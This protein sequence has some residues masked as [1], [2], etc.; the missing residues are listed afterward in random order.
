MQNIPCS[1]KSLGG[2]YYHRIILR[3]KKHSGHVEVTEKLIVSNGIQ[4]CIFGF[5]D[6]QANTEYV[7]DIHVKMIAYYVTLNMFKTFM[8]K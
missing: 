6:P 2:T 7:L 8:S 4:N 3:T 5:V 1:L